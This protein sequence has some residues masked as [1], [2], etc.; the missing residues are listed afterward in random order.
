MTHTVVTTAPAGSAQPA[1]CVSLST[2]TARKHRPSSHPACDPH[3]S[4]A[5]ACA[6]SAP[7]SCPPVKTIILHR[8]CTFTVNNTETAAEVVILL[9]LCLNRPLFS[10][11][12]RNAS[13]PRRL[14]S[15]N[16]SSV[17]V[18]R[19]WTESGLSTTTLW[20]GPS[21]RQIPRALKSFLALPAA[22]SSPPGSLHHR[23]RGFQ[24]ITE[25]P[26]R[27]RIRDSLM[28]PLYRKETLWS[29]TMQSVCSNA[30]ITPRLQ[31]L[32]LAMKTNWPFVLTMSEAEGKEVMMGTL[33][34]TL[35]GY[36]GK[37]TKCRFSSVCLLRAIWPVVLCFWNEWSSFRGNQHRDSHGEVWVSCHKPLTLQLRPGSMTP[38]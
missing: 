10:L 9:T 33:C 30:Q 29:V 22:A 17:Q 5:S 24:Q 21:L 11:L 34:S 38:H 4:Q 2:D 15:S 28:Q 18:L 6:P 25:D 16:G 31:I 14:S 13:W 32:F 8:T 7:R 1:R 26:D 20:W 37:D 36:N 27:S 12:L 19:K 35:L 3:L 23:T